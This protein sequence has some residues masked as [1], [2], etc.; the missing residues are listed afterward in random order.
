M[1]RDVDVLVVGAGVVGI[2]AAH[3]LAAS[4]RSVTVVDRT[5]L[6]AGCSHGNAGLVVPSHAIP[7]AAPGALWQGIKWMFDPESP[8]YIKP[9]ASLALLGWLFRFGLACS[10]K[11]VRRAIP[12]LR[13]LHRASAELYETLADGYARRG[14]LILYRTEAGFE[15]GRHEAQVLLDAGIETKVL[16]VPGVR[17]L[18]PGL[19]AEVVG[20]IHCLEDAHLDP[21]RFVRRLA[22]RSGVEIRL[23]T[24]EGFDIQGRRIAQVRTSDGPIAAK[25]VVLAAGS[26]APGLARDL[27]LRIPI[28]AGKGY[29]LTFPAPAAAPEVPFILGEDRVAVTPLGDRLRLAGTMELAG[30]DLSVNERR[31]AAIRRAGTAALGELGEPEE[32]WAGLRPVTPDT[33]PLLGRP[34]RYDN[35]IV[36]AGH[37][38]IGLSLGPVTGRIVADLAAGRDPGLDLSLLDPDRF[39]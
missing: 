19:K 13:D 4:G 39:G 20:G 37:A 38:M 34:R 15:S 1:Q 8:L 9:R 10:E 36:A 6:A 3:F 33:L 18:L 28:Q 5:G 26:W 2:S 14:L 25:E 32:V 31:V 35:L 7:L 30:L 22:A 24:V 12:V 29:S 23:T 27:R 21:L 11:R 17:A 16:D